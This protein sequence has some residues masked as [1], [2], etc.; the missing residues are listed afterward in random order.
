MVGLT[1]YHRARDMVGLTVYHRARDMVGLPVH[2][3]TE[4]NN[5]RCHTDQKYM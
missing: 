2:H 1:V 5:N 4:A 3:S